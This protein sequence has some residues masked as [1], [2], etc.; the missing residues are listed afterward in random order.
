MTNPMNEQ[1][2]KG[3]DGFLDMTEGLDREEK[4]KFLMA[5]IITIYEEAYAAAKPLPIT[6]ASTEKL[7]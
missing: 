1:L 7:N 6:I 2:S 5:L 4:K 3:L